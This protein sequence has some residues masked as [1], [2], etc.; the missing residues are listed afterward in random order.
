MFNAISRVPP[1][2]AQEA[3]L[4]GAIRTILGII[5]F[6]MTFFTPLYVGIP[7]MVGMSL[8][9]A[10]DK[11]KP[12]KANVIQYKT[13]TS[14][15]ASLSTLASILDR[16][17]RTTLP[18]SAAELEA[19]KNSVYSGCT[20]LSQIGVTVGQDGS[21][22]CGDL[23]LP[24]LVDITTVGYSENSLATIATQ[25]KRLAPLEQKFKSF[26]MKTLETQASKLKGK[27]KQFALEA[28]SILDNVT[29]A[30]FTQGGKAAHL[31]VNTVNDIKHFYAAKDGSTGKD[32]ELPSEAKPT[33]KT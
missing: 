19:F 13:L 17:N 31:V 15:M 26:S 11:D 4:E 20:S 18:K 32:T 24:K 9:S 21:I 8:W 7:L 1:H 29:H 23:E 33:P 14:Y 16:I 10:S 6:F 25:A 3:A 30:I 2:D 5:T 27:Q 22:T 12:K 28:V